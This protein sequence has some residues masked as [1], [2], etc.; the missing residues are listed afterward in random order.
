MHVA[1]AL[2]DELVRIETEGEHEEE[3]VSSSEEEDDAIPPP[4]KSAQG[5]CCVVDDLNRG[6]SLKF[7]PL[8][9]YFLYHEKYSYHLLKNRKKG[10]L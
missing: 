10:H 5:L 3:A 1:K 2:K 6:G 9:Y 7:I 8:M 4:G